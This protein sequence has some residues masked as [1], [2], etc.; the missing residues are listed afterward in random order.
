VLESRLPD[1]GLN[2]AGGLKEGRKMVLGKVSGVDD[3]S[4]VFVAVSLQV[5]E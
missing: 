3:E 1:V 5:L 2:T 4:A